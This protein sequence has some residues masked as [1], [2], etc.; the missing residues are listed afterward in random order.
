MSLSLQSAQDQ[1][2]GWGKIHQRGLSPSWIPLMNSPESS[3][4]LN[5]GWACSAVED[6]SLEA[7]L[8]SSPLPTWSPHP[9]PEEGVTDNKD[10]ESAPHHNLLSPLKPHHHHHRRTDLLSISYVPGSMLSTSSV[11]QSCN[12]YNHPMRPYDTIIF[13]TL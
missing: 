8:T 7:S 3:S 4:L 10:G 11:L 2:W 9:H 5:S 13:L 1:R 6:A 12:L